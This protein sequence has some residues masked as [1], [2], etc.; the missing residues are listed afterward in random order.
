M[1]YPSLMKDHFSQTNRMAKVHSHLLTV[2]VTKESLNMENF[3]VK[4]N[5]A[6][7]MEQSTKEAFTVGKWMANVKFNFLQNPK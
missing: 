1:S 3:M 4:G 2:I 7:Q 6:F 5:I